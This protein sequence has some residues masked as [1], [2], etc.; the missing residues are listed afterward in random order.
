MPRWG[1]LLAAFSGLL[2]TPVVL[3]ALF[4]MILRR[5]LQTR[6]AVPAGPLVPDMPRKSLE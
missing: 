4:A 5:A 1:W 6:V 3:L 2:L